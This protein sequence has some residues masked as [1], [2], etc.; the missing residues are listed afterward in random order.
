MKK[1]LVILGPT[2]T[3]KTDLALKLAKKFNGELIS[4]DSRQVY[5]GLDIGTGKMPINVNRETI[6]NKLEIENLKFKI[7]Q[8]KGYWI[9][10]GI[11]IW[12]YDVVDPKKQ[13]SVADYIKEAPLAIKQIRAKGKLPIIVGGTGL[14]LKAL[15]EGLP[16]LSIPVDQALRKQLQKLSLDKLQEKLQIVSIKGWKKMNQSDRGNTRRLIRAIELS[17]LS[18]IGKSPRTLSLARDDIMKI[19]LIAPREILYKKVD[20]RVIERIDQGMIDEAKSLHKNGL[21]YKRMKQLGLE[22]GVL[23]D[24]L[25]GHITGN[26]LQNKQSLLARRLA[27]KIH[28]YVRRQL[29]WFKKE[30]NTFWFNIAEKNSSVNVEKMI[31][32][33]YHASNVTKD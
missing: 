3:G 13:Y 14:Y 33:W 12:M 25:E 20:H 5:K 32:K 24:Y 18:P 17:T 26:D 8:G 15:L 10:N 23:A 6:S 28:G 9:I 21:T 11:R 1:L 4:C 22:Y 16:N 29:T 31:V 30:K 27:S 2:A 7:E 19:G